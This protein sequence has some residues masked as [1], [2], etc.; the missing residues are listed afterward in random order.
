MTE[1]ANPPRARRRIGWFLPLVGAP[2]VFFVGIFIAGVLDQL[3]APEPLWRVP[4]ALAIGGSLVAVVV[5]LIQVVRA[6]GPNAGRLTPAEAAQQAAEVEE[7]VRLTGEQPEPRRISGVL[8]A[9]AI[10]LTILSAIILVVAFQDIASILT[11]PGGSKAW[12]LLAIV[13][14][15]AAWWRF[16]TARAAERAYRSGQEARQART[17]PGAA[18]EPG[19]AGGWPQP[20][21]S[22]VR[23][24]RHRM[25]V[26]PLLAIPAVI[27]VA[28]LVIVGLRAVDAPTEAIRTVSFT[29]VAG[30]IVALVTLVVGVVRFLSA[31]PRPR[32]PRAP[33]VPTAP[34]QAGLYADLAAQDAARQGL[35]LEEYGVYKGDVG[36][37]VR[38][39]TSAGGLLFIAILLTV[40]NVFIL[41]LIGVGIAQ[42]N[43]LV[44]TNPDDHALSPVQW[45]FLVL[46]MLFVPVA[47]WYYLV[48]RRAQKLRIAR[49]LPK[50]LGSAELP[51]P[52]GVVTTPPNTE[53]PGPAP[54]P[55]PVPV[56][57]PGWDGGPA[58]Q[59]AGGPDWAASVDVH[60][61]DALRWSIEQEISTLRGFRR[62]LKTDGEYSVFGL[63]LGIPFLVPQLFGAIEAFTSAP[64]P[65]LGAL[66]EWISRPAVAGWVIVG[67]LL[68]AVSVVS[69]QVRVR[70]E[71]AIYRRAGWVALQAPTGLVEWT[72]EG[73]PH[74]T[75]DHRLV[76]GPRE[77][78]PQDLGRAFMLVSGP[79]M[80]SP[81]FVGALRAVRA[82]TVARRLEIHRLAVLRQQI[83]SRR[84][85]PAPLVFE[86]TDGCLFGAQ[87]DGWLTVVIPR[88]AQDAQ[89]IRL[90][91]VKLTRAE[92][93]SLTV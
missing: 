73:S 80:P 6:L 62:R 19:A 61:L 53:G 54:G 1:H 92:R 48:E 81:V 58:P 59:W 38:P 56:P 65:G 31:P 30:I 7:Y 28:V 50:T 26:L 14:T 35:T 9:V 43:G 91:R 76:G 33:G 15:P 69:I 72:G 34:R 75:Y 41:V 11:A 4:W 46:E 23:T 93:E 55:A 18:G 37:L 13:A 66:R 5:F 22:A 78:R 17:T 84:A 79:R 39:V 77:V 27:V 82:T 20:G 85:I 45:G 90:A 21:P 67:L 42:A 88:P 8:L 74:I 10:V 51:P 57:A 40:L 32:A 36:S 29:M 60:R 2:V 71:F 52:L 16:A 83:G 70:R 12:L 49:G 44:P 64:E 68:I 87:H 25:W 89:R 47:W 86:R 24:R 63:V 3:G